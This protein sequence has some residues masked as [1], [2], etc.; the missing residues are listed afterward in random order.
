MGW[1]FLP[2]AADAVVRAAGELAPAAV[3]ISG[4]LVQR[5]DFLSLWEDAR[6]FVERL[7]LPRLIVPGNH[8]IPLFNPFL[9]AFA[10]LGRYKKY[11]SPEVDPVLA[12]PGATIIG[13]NSARA[14]LVDQGRVSDAQL[15]RVRR[16]CADAPA[17]ALRVVAMHHPIVPQPETGLGR[18][19]VFGH[20]RAIR[21]MA[22]AGVDLVLCGHNH[23]PNALNVVEHLPEGAGLVLAQAGT[24]TSKRIRPKTGTM[25]QTF[26]VIRSEPGEIAIEAWHFRGGRFAPAKTTK[27]QRRRAIG[28]VAPIETVGG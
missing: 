3:V 10:P 18:Q 24:A 13:I 27:F 1:P 14:W 2:D 8:D 5:G 28:G 16:V 25:E 19:H 23:F 17:D 9:R 12:V 15:E 26:N 6:A 21:A 20:R 4:D 11:I 7:P 22:Q